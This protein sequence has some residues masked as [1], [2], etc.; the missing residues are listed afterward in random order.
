[1]LITPFNF[2]PASIKEIDALIA[3]I[4]KIFDYGDFPLHDDYSHLFN[5]NA[6]S[7]SIYIEHIFRRR[8]TVTIKI[9]ESQKLTPIITYTIKL[10]IDIVKYLY[11][12]FKIFDRT[13][14]IMD[15]KGI[16]VYYIMNGQTVCYPLPAST[17]P[18]DS[19]HSLS[20]RNNLIYKIQ[21]KLE[22]DIPTCL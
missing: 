16:D 21:K 9:Y 5:A 7:Y 11:N 22:Q 12:I 17:P 15:D 6:Q 2:K 1:M 4:V 3:R 8:G 20:R 13:K 14:G 18:W 10:D 19:T